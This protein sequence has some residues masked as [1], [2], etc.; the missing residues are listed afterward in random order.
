MQTEDF[1]RL[2]AK[3]QH[4]LVLC[5]GGVR[6]SVAVPLEKLRKS[7]DERAFCAL[8]AANE[9]RMDFVLKLYGFQEQFMQTAPPPPEGD[10]PSAATYLNACIEAV[11]AEAARTPTDQ[12]REL[13]RAT[14]LRFGAHFSGKLI[15]SNAQHAAL[16]AS[17]RPSTQPHV[18]SRA[19]ER[20][21]IRVP[22]DQSRLDN[23]GTYQRIAV[24]LEGDSEIADSALPTEHIE[25]IRQGAAQA[26]EQAATAGG[27]DAVDH[28]LRQILLPSNGQYIAV[29]PLP[30]AGLAALWNARG[31]AAPSPTPEATPAQRR[32]ETV[33]LPI[34]GAIV[35]NTTRLPASAIQTQLFFP[36]PQTHENIQALFRFVYRGWTPQ[37]QSSDVDA[38]AA[39]IER[40]SHSPTLGDSAS[41]LA[42][43]IQATGALASLARNCHR[44]ATDLAQD[45]E[46]GSFPEDSEQV[47][48]D[49]PLLR[50][51]RAGEL[52]A[53][54]T[55][56]LRQ[57]FGAEYRSELA[58]LI[59]RTLRA[60]MRRTEGTDALMREIDRER[61][62]RAL[63]QALERL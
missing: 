32:L 45:I 53:I 42:V 16:L 51:K 46:Q 2:R 49:E 19:L 1:E 60:R 40:L 55:A 50:R 34:G 14:V 7:D 3:H 10:E 57:S 59:V 33:E 39:Q 25:A 61:V 24:I 47:P 4:L 63:E 43:G 62:T 44:Q 6:R 21:G 30:S 48:I 31:T 36:V 22:L 27:A 35:R 9:P 20:A 12:M 58:R 29:S 54:D 15:N 41:L 11:R 13:A 8:C 26:F 56:I 5:K 18:T 38:A 37:M 17:A 28:R 23:S 52:T